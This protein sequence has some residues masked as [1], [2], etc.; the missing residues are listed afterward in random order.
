[1]DQIESWKKQ[2]KEE[3]NKSDERTLTKDRID[4]IWK[5][6]ATSLRIYE[7][8]LLLFPS[9]IQESSLPYWYFALRVIVT[10]S[11]QSLSL[12]LSR[13]IRERDSD[14]ERERE[15]SKRSITE[16][17]KSRT[18]IKDL[19]KTSKFLER[20]PVFLFSFFAL[21]LLRNS[22]LL[23]SFLSFSKLSLQD[24]PYPS[25]SYIYWE[26]CFYSSFLSSSS[27][28]N[29]TGWIKTTSGGVSFFPSVGCL[30]NLPLFRGK[31]VRDL[32]FVHVRK[33]F[34]EWKFRT[35]TKETFIT[36][37]SF[38]PIHLHHMPCLI[39]CS[40]ISRCHPL[41]CFNPFFSSFPLSLSLFLLTWI[42][43]L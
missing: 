8:F 18:E 4:R 5:S 39:L 21:F 10:E 26:F 16:L 42:T 6:V 12:S 2:G 19:P 28:L 36:F 23:I 17:S 25:I 27:N 9:L 37:R 33:S 20:F 32:L 11:V 15:Q 24:L 34:P 30:K 14:R 31:S 13:R 22:S 41:H 43:C 29:L 7:S 38:T 1:M 40:S 3:W 35:C